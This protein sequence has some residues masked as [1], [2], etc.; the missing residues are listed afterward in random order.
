MKEVKILQAN[1]TRLM[2]EKKMTQTQVA[3][4]AGISQ[5]S[6]SNAVRAKRAQQLD[7]IIGIA[8]A[9][10]VSVSELLSAT[11]G[12]I[13]PDAARLLE[14]YIPLPQESRER[15]MHSAETEARYQEILSAG[16]ERH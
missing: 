7:V 4:R 9:L 10:N 12:D 13:P 8:K 1:L 3:Q 11:P 5:G 2:A 15:V 16:Q 14:L 6:V